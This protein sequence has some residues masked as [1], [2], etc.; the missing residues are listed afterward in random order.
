MCICR[1]IYMCMQRSL[2]RYI[3]MCTTFGSNIQPGTSLAMSGAKRKVPTI[4]DVPELRSLSRTSIKALL[5][6]LRA[7]PALLEVATHT[8]G[9][10][11][12]R[13]VGYFRTEHYLYANAR[14]VVCRRALICSTLLCA[15]L[16]LLCCL[17]ICSTLLCAVLL[18][19]C[20]VCLR[21]SG[22]DSL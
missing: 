5:E 12:A 14:F 6:R 11:D 21:C 15:V 9:Q 7:Q 13:R 16:A 18:L 10:G 19:L 22:D 1:Y 20:C 17:Y 4:G 3:P 2:A 8:Y